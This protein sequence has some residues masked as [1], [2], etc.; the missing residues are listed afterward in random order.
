MVEA[1]TSETSENFCQTTHSNIPED[2]D[3]NS[4]YRDNLKCQQI[5]LINVA[6]SE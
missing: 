1:V 6:A 5:D 2:G 3:P 4:S